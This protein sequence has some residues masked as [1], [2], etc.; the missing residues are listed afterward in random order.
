MIA[1][2]NVKVTRDQ[3]GKLLSLLEKEKIVEMDEEK[4]QQLAQ[5]QEKQQP[6]P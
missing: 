1:E 2:E 6:K 5:Q 4:A 3:L